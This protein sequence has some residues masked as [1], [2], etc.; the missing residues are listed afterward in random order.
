[1]EV[2]FA[3]GDR[4][5]SAGRVRC[6]HHFLAFEATDDNRLAV[7]RNPVDRPG[8]FHDAVGLIGLDFMP[9]VVK[10][11]IALIF[12]VGLT[13]QRSKSG[14]GVVA[15]VGN[16][17]F[18][19]PALQQ[20][21]P[22]TNGFIQITDDAYDEFQDTPVR[23]HIGHLR[24]A[25]APGLAHVPRKAIRV[26]SVQFLYIPTGIAG[27]LALVCLLRTD[28]TILIFP[29]SAQWPDWRGVFDVCAESIL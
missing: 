23:S 26:E 18:S 1:M 6:R 15:F 20:Y 2:R 12:K 11:P 4:D 7:G 5:R 21:E 14:W 24:A 17:T 22:T 27:R 8:A 9:G 16:T 29:K 19:S 10:S 25:P 13:S 28:S 3:G